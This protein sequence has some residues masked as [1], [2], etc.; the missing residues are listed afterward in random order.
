MYIY[1]YVVH[2][3][4]QSLQQ[5]ATTSTIARSNNRFDNKHFRSSLETN[6]TTTC[7]ADESLISYWRVVTV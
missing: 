1:I 7:A 5:P 6:T 3:F 4:I 2:K